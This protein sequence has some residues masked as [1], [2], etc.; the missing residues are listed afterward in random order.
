LHTFRHI[1]AFIATAAAITAAVLLGH[2]GNAHPTRQP[3]FPFLFRLLLLLL[4]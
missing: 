2:A 1:L 3:N 4:L